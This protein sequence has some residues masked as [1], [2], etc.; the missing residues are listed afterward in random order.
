MRVSR[1]LACV[2][3]I[4][5]VGCRA[6]HQ[7]M[8]SRRDVDAIKAGY[9]EWKHGF[10]ARD[11]RGVM[12]IY[13]PDVVAYDLVP[14]L[15]LIGSDAYR[16]SYS[17]FFAEFKGPIR[18]SYQNIDVEQSGDIAFAFGLE[19]LRGTLADGKPVDMWIRFS[20][21]W[22]RENGQWRVVHEHVSVPVDMTT[23][24]ARSDLTPQ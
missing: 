16:Q 17:N 6:D 4:L 12:A 14:P 22:R 5:L 10:E 8:N 13:A 19:R 18:V 2:L 23:G 24:K 1:N 20:G 3:L 9:R 21:G 11:V 7:S 15:Q